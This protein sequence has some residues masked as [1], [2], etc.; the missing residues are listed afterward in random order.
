MLAALFKR[1]FF[2]FSDSSRALKDLL[3]KEKA[4]FEAQLADFPHTFQLQDLE[5]LRPSCIKS[6]KSGLE[7]ALSVGYET[8]LETARARNL[9]AF[10]LWNLDRPDDALK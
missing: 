6:L 8:G 4:T 2:H 5:S 7:S 3:K 1:V 10:V 9:L